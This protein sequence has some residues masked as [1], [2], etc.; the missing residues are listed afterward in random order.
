M[1][2]GFVWWCSHMHIYTK[3]I[4]NHKKTI[5]L[6]QIISKCNI[7]ALS[8]IIIIIIASSLKFRIDEWD[9]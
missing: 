3:N 7:H 1:M 6:H 9:F 5:L 4:P 8:M 2:M